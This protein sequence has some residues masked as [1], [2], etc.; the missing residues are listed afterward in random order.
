MRCL[1]R[2]V[3]TVGRIAAMRQVAGD[4]NCV[5]FQLLDAT[6]A[7]QI[8]YYPDA[9]SDVRRIPHFRLLR[10]QRSAT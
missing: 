9:E 5:D 2:Q 7:I 6:G 4:A 8:L 3:T 10:V 1:L